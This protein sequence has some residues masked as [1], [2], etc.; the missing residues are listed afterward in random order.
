MISLKEWKSNVDDWN[1]DIYELDENNKKFVLDNYKVVS[2]SSEQTDTKN[3]NKS[4]NNFN[5]DEV[6]AKNEYK[7]MEDIDI[8]ALM[9]DVSVWM[10]D[11]SDLNVNTY[12]TFMKLLNWQIAA[13]KHFIIELNI[14]KPQEKTYTNLIRSSYKLCTARSD[15]KFHYPDNMTDKKGC[16]NQ[17]YPYAQL[18]VDCMSVLHYVTSFFNKGKNETK[19]DKLIATFTQH[20]HDFDYTDLNRC[21]RTINFVISAV[22][23][24]L[25]NVI[26]YRSSDKDFNIRNY[27]YH[28]EKRTNK[29]KNN[30]PRNNVTKKI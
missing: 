11:N 24:E 27:H 4:V 9:V 5:I 22:H 30:N 28:S 19:A 29:N 10:I 13:I 6:L 20:Q 3:N 14:T 18:Y 12:N 21:L 1:K 25:D 7:S 26:R 23:K 2:K 16:N 8:L 15:C 17:H